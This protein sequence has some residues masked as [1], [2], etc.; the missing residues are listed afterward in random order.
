MLMLAYYQLLIISNGHEIRDNI[1]FLG[2]LFDE[3][4]V[5]N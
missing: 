1:Q 2:K 5:M 3:D 4:R